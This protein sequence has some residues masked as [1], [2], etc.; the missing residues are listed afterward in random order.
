MCSAGL[1]I[2]WSSVRVNVPLLRSSRPFWI[3]VYYKDVAPT[4]RYPGLVVSQHQMRQATDAPECELSRLM[5]Q[6]SQSQRKVMVGSD[7]HGETAKTHFSREEVDPI[8]R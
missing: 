8:G 5:N 4:E 7:H 2:C 6:F 3:I 1:K